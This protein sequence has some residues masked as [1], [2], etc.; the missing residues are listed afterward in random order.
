[1]APAPD[2]VTEPTEPEARA[3]LDQY[4]A[5]FENA[6]ASALE[7]LLRRDATLEATPFTTWFAGNHTCVPYLRAWVLG[8]PGDWLMLPTRANNQPA[9]MAYTRDPHGTYQAYGLAVLTVTKTSIRHIH[10]FHDPSL[11]GLFGFPTVGPGGES[12]RSP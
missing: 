6:D 8:S 11:S 4:I 5:A 1:M 9:A 3:L 12:L 2:D 7:H 10:A